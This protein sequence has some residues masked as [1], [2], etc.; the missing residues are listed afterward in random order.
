MYIKLQGRNVDNFSDET[1]RLYELK[2]A[3]TAPDPIHTYS[4]NLKG[5]PIVID[6]GRYIVS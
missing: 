5:V 6:N 1:V 3:R 4:D 2:D